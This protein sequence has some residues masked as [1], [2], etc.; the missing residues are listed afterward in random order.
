M[1]ISF[2][3][4]TARD[5]STLE[6]DL[7]LCE[8]AGFDYIEIRIHMLKDYL[9][10]HKVYDLKNFFSYSHLKPHA[11]NALYIFNAMFSDRMDDL[12]RERERSLMEDFMLTCEVGRSIGSK[13]LI[14]VPDIYSNEANTKRY[15]D[16]HENIFR[17]SV[18]ILTKLADIAREYDMNLCWEPVG[19]I[20]CAVKT[21]EQAWEI[22]KAVDK[23]NV[24]VVLDCFNLYL[25]DKCADF[26]MMRDVDPGKV[27]AVHINNADDQP[28]GILA[29][30]HRRFCDTGTINLESFLGTLKDIGYDDMISIETFRPEYWEKKPEWVISE[31]YRTTRDA[32]AAFGRL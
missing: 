2:N 7:T 23:S 26:S 9:K 16:T 27:F 24:G 32:V 19:C 15:I 20:G 3:E 1:K 22:V 5:C 10:T 6:Q 29:H 17:D 14:V 31:A 28:L 8:Q 11:F 12:E 25:Y 4:A 30:C 13:Y 21:V 18:R